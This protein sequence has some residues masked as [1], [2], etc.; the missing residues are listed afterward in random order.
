MSI[1]M[2][3]GSLG[4][5]IGLVMVMAVSCASS[6]AAQIPPDAWQYQRYLT[7]EAQAQFGVTAPVARMAAQI[8]QESAWRPAVCSHAGACGLAQFIPSTANW[9]AEMHPR[10]L[11]PADP[12]NPLWAIQAQVRYNHWLEQRIDAANDCALWAMLL[13]AYNGGIGW[14]GRDRQLAE[15]D[16]ANKDYWFGQ[17]EKY[18]QRADWACEEN[19]GYVSRILFDLEPRYSDAG[20]PGRPVCL[21]Q[22]RQCAL[23]QPCSRD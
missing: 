22:D 14:L 17:V 10:T 21:R 18:S 15:Q 23:V 6:A 13:S 5:L 8:H 19:R 7:R 2:G 20:W 3:R 11:A 4:W 12:A 16:G 9:M 1:R